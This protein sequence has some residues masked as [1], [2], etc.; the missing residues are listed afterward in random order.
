MDK[1]S[2]A[3]ELVILDQE[4]DQEIKVKISPYADGIGINVEGYGDYS[5]QD[6]H[7][8]CLYV[9]HYAGELRVRVYRNINIEEP[10][11]ISMKE[12]REINRKQDE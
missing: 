10:L 7:G 8:E 9:E 6:G 5:S 11:V 2:K 4:T 12:A 1:H 3:I